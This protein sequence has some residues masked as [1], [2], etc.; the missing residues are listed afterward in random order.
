MFPEIVPVPFK[1]A[2]HGCVSDSVKLKVLPSTVPDI[3]PVPPVE[4]EKVPV[5]VLPD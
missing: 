4:V 2:I 5:T 3:D 1:V